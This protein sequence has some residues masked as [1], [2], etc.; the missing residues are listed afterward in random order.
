MGLP[1]RDANLHTYGDYVTWAADDRYELIDGVAYLMAPAPTVGHQVL[2]GELHRQ[3]A[4][5]LRG[6]PCR[7]F[8]APLDVRLPVGEQDDDSIETVVQPD[9]FVVCDTNKI[10]SRGVRGAPDWLIEV[11]SPSTA[12]HDQTLKLR[13]YERAGVREVWLAHPTDRT[14][15]V[16]SLVD[17]RYGR[18]AI[19]EMNGTLASIAVSLVS[20]DWELTKEK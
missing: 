8:I 9:V 18:P 3:I 19:S 14:V 15:A 5:A 2:A 7:P 1:R 12:G 20:I 13:V 4:N 16:Y 17:G 11:S 10:D 6:H